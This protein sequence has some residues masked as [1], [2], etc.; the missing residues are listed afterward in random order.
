LEKEDHT[1]YIFEAI[2]CQDAGISAMFSIAPAGVKGEKK[3]D[4]HSE[5]ATGLAA[6][7]PAH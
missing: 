5:W 6:L 1:Y 2:S 4:T 7:L 3:P